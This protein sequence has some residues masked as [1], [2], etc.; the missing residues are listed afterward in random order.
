VGLLYILCANREGFWVDE[1]MTILDC[2]KSYPDMIHEHAMIG[3]I[4]L[5]FSI[6]WV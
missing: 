2:A 6:M 5:Y 4:P 1:V 3:H